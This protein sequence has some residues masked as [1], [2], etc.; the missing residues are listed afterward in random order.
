MPGVTTAEPSP[1]IALRYFAFSISPREAA[2]VRRLLATHGSVRVRAIVKSRYFQGV[3]PYVTG[4]IP[5]TGQEE[6]LTLGHNSE[7]GAEDN[8]TGVSAMLEA[9]APLNR[10]I[11][12]DRLPR[13]KRSIRI[14]TMPEM[15][16]S[17]HYI[18]T[19]P[20]RMRRTIAGITVDPPA[21][22]YEQALTD[23]TFSV[24]PQVASSYVDAFILKVA[25]DYFPSIDLG[26]HDYCIGKVGRPWH[27][28]R[29]MA[30]S[31]GYLSDP[32]IGVADVAIS[33]DSGVETHHNSEDTPNRID[34]RSLRDLSVVD[35]TFLYYLANAGEDEAAWL[36]IRA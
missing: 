25:E 5:G 31:D 10:L 8:A 32:A 12:S 1:R 23:Y 2:L 33:S 24:D 17:M 18:A 9:A 26:F 16:G 3:Y 6:V 4:V 36:Y 13:L 27:G 14:L 28:H 35:A 19:H 29:Y 11:A 7:Q 22:P 20:D 21:G 30:W 15:Y 34:P